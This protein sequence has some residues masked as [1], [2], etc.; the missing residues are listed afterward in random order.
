MAKDFFHEQVKSALKKEGWA[1]THDPYP[2][3]VGTI[4]YEVDLEQK[5]LLLQKK[6]RKRSL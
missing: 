3:S 2:L 1:I 4:G 5:S 6:A